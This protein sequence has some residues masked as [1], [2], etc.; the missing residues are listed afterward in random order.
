MSSEEEIRRNS[1]DQQLADAGWSQEKGNLRTEFFMRKKSTHVHESGEEY[2]NRSSEDQRRFA[3]YVLL[4]EH[5]N[6]LAI[7]EAKRDSRSPLEGMEQAAEYAESIYEQTG[8]RPYIFLSNGDEIYFWEKD[9]YPPRKVS[10]FYTTQDLRDLEQLRLYS[11]PL[12]LFKPEASIVERAYQE[13]AIQTIID[14]I[15]QKKRKFLLVMATGTGK[16]RTVIALID[17]LFRAGWIRRVLFLA[18]RREL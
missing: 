6:P 16:T 8:K 15:K 13:R 7:V 4:D 12:H 9:R 14:G 10:G 17:L 18:D 11:Q 3:D 1:I 2:S 5:G